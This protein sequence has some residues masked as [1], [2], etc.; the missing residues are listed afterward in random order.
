M[1]IKTVDKDLEAL[2]LT[3]V[4]EFDADLQR[5]W[6]AYS[7][8]RQIEKFWGPPTWPATF[9]RHD[10]FV[11]GQSHYFMTGPDG[12]K[13]AGYWEFLA[14]DAPHSFEVVD[15][16]AHEDGTFNTDLPTTRFTM[17]FEDIGGRTRMTSISY[18]NTLE[19]L[20]Q[21]VEMGM[22]EG[23]QAAMGQIDDVLADLS[24]FAVGNGVDTALVTDATVRVSRIIRGT[25]EQV[26]NAHHDP[27][28]M[29]R[30]MLGPDGWTMPVCEVATNVG[31]SYR[32]EWENEE[33]QESFGFVGELLESD[34][35]HR[36]VVTEQMIGV[37]GPGAVNEL[38]IRPVDGGT[39]LTV[40]M[41][42]PTKEIRDTVLATGMT[43]GME[44]SYARLE[45]VVLS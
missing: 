31:D 33:S 17:N 25:V 9:T 11:G 19:E 12:D 43:D 21:L 29:R 8:P 18:F 38:T 14:V 42:F 3:I 5:V 30:W 6:D 20:Q 15:G 4:A 7:D 28:L 37:D 35:P 41:N 27:E 16:F 24:S 36:T 44:A 10:M 39:L 13:A 32:Y 1:P 2:T 45:S 22:E 40:V 23:M 34:R 26:W